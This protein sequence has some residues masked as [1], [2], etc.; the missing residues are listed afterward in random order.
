MDYQ[1]N[2]NI[3][4]EHTNN[5]CLA[6]INGVVDKDNDLIIIKLNIGR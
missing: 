5:V 1:F 6:H 2:W 3:A 4:K